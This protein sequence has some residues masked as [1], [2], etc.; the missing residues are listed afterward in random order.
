MERLQTLW[1]QVLARTDYEKCAR[2]RAAR[3]SLSP[4]SQLCAKLGVV[5][6]SATVVHIAGSKGKGS[7]AHFCERG[8]RAGGLRTGLFTSPHL[9][10][11]RER[12]RIN[13]ALIG[14]EAVSSALEQVLA[15]S[16]GEETFFDLITATACVAFTA[17]ECDVWVLETGLGGR[18]DSTNAISSDAA[19]VTSLELEHTD[20]L[21]ETIEQIASE[22]AGIYKAGARCWTGV[23]AD[24]PGRAVL[25]SA[26]AAID[27]ELRTIPDIDSDPASTSFPGGF[28]YRQPHMRAN[29][30]L[31]VAV[32]DDLGIDT[33]AMVGN[34]PNPANAISWQL[35]GRFEPR[36]LPDGRTVIFDI[37]HSEDSLRSV[38]SAYREQWPHQCRGIL[39]ALRDDKDAVSLAA[40]LAVDLPA[41]TNTP[42]EQSRPAEIWF[43]MP[44]GDHP[45]S[46]DPVGLAAA[47]A[48]F[49][50]I[51]LTQPEF[52]TASD[53]L[54]V[55]GST[56]LVGALRPLT[57]PCPSTKTP[58]FA[59]PTEVP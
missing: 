29:F 35:P 13:G 45:R 11:W 52:P 47:F 41:P 18:F 26:A 58:K 5:N 38:L 22:K 46:A 17:A 51:P 25:A 54:L 23:A 39:L 27:T 10:D 9:S 12:I 24:H 4:A 20:V 14:V 8:A 34:S 59:T 56:Y 16:S 48:G 42:G 50:A 55:T 33:Q 21:G 15:S 43:T 36:H 2:P 44:A 53:V 3:F 32:L 49:S 7:I 57:T 19:V 6:P 37:A 30:K 28:P 1:Q 31:A 40:A